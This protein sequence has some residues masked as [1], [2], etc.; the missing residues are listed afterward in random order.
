MEFLSSY[1]ITS[2][3]IAAN[4]VASF[5]AFANADFYE[6]NLFRI[7]NITRRNEYHRAL[8][9]GFLHVNPTH[10]LMNMFVLWMFGPVLERIFG[11]VGYLIV[12][13]GA[14]LGASAWM[15]YEK[16]NQ[17]NYSAVGASGAVSGVILAYC[18]FY[19]FNMLYLFFAIPIPAV[20]FGVGYIVLSYMLSQRE[21]AVVAHGAH[22]GGALAGL[23]LTI[24]LKPEALTSFLQAVTG[25]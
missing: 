7:G 20:V 1:P 6:Q 16:R 19:P 21:K 15:L 8:T 4:L 14:L 5:F 25:G 17:L 2:A 3:L 10:L 9:S 13:F 22:L 12:Y 18:L 23:V 24:L 11:P